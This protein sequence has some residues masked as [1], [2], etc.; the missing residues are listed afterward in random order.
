MSTVHSIFVVLVFLSEVI[1]DTM[2][3]FVSV[4]SKNME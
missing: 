1:T 2:L 4:D 3:H